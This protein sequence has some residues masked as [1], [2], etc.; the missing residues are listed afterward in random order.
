MWRVSVLFFGACSF[1]Y[2]LP[3][4]ST[5]TSRCDE[6][7]QAP[8]TDTIVGAATLSAAIA[9]S[10][11]A[12]D[13]ETYRDGKLAYWLGLVPTALLFSSSAV[14]GYLSRD[15]CEHVHARNASAQREV[16]R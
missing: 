7:Y 14:Y 9:L 6:S 8:V 2:M 11:A 13:K 1:T 12:I 3:P 15:H 4:V 10:G 16:R 5:M